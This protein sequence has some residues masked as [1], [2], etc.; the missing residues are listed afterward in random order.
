MACESCHDPA[1]KH[2]ESASAADIVNPSKL[3]AAA[4]DRT[5][6]KCHLNEPT[7]S[8]RIRS[9]HAKDDVSCTSCHAIH[10]GAE[11]L[12]PTK[13]ADINQQC[14]TCHSAVWAQFQKPYKH[15]LPEGA[16]ACTDCHNPHGGFLPRSVRT[17][18]ANEPTCFRCHSDKRGPFTFEHAPVR[19][20]GCATCHEPHGS[21]NPR[22]LVRREVRF[23]CLQCHSNIAAGNALG[24]NPPG[25][26][27]L[28]ST[29]YRNCTICH[30]KIH[31]SYVDSSLE[32]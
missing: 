4:T 24:G 18:A 16:M 29:R 15:R 22:M 19:L 26:H 14:S 9:S 3:A 20:E 13:P 30:T 6:L 12:R 23:L 1:A 31:G 8:G 5:C 2:T 28:R 21:A 7:H 27:D 17:V 11:K 25:F 32:R 10:Q